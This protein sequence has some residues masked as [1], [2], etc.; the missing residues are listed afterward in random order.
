MND[1]EII[2]KFMGHS[3]HEYTSW[4][5]IMEVVDKIEG[6]F[7]SVYTHIMKGLTISSGRYYMYIEVDEN[8]KYIRAY[9]G[10]TKFDAV[11][12]SVVEFIK[13]YNENSTE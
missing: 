11:K 13:W 5:Q 2:A 12:K 4:D 1:N 8:P 10:K 9:Y 7:N 6:T 3:P